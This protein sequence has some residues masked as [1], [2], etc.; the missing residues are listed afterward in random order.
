[1]R[2]RLAHNK[3]LFTV[4]WKMVSLFRMQ[5]QLFQTVH[6]T[7]LQFLHCTVSTVWQRR[8]RTWGC[9][10]VFWQWFRQTRT[11]RSFGQMER[12]SFSAC[13]LQVDAGY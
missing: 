11:I 13:A 8:T 7:L 1:M 12:A 2:Q 4:F 10:K 6:V 9:A 5:L 3:L